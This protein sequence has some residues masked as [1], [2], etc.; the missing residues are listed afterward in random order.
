[1][2][3]SVVAN[4]G[5]T[6]TGK[7]T[8]SCVGLGIPCVAGDFFEFTVFFSDTTVTLDFA[9]ATIQDAT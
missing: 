9:S 8:H 1:L 4:Q 5:E 7:N 3:E 2:I 6:I